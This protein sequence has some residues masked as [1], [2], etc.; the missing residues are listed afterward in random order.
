MKTKAKRVERFFRSLHEK[1]KDRNHALLL[2]AGTMLQGPCFEGDRL[3]ICVDGGLLPLSMFNSFL[4]FKFVVRVVAAAQSAQRT[5]GIPA[6][7]LI[8]RAAL[9]S[10]YG[11]TELA[12]KYGE[13]FKES[14]R[15]LSSSHDEGVERSFLKEAKRLATHPKIRS[16]MRNAGDPILYVCMLRDKGFWNKLY[17][18]DLTSLIVELELQEC[19]RAALCPPGTYNKRTDPYAPKPMYEKMWLL[20]EPAKAS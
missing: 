5:Y 18:S 11:S 17:C 4:M 19:D 13:Y 8:A 2:S 14:S 3:Q 1:A 9:E 6:S 16:E 10:A 20:R 15:R 7:V 12:V